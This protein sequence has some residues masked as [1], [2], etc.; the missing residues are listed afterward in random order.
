MRRKL[1]MDSGLSGAQILKMIAP[2]YLA[3]VNNFKSET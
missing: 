1:K 3:L 2:D